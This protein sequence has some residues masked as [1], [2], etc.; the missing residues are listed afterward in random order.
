MTGLRQ[1]VYV[2]ECLEKGQSQQ[3]IVDKFEGDKQLVDLWI[4]FLN[5]NGWMDKPDGKYM[6]ANKGKMWIQRLKKAKWR[7]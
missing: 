1:A 6:D 5:G 2:L 7:S 3:E 4:A